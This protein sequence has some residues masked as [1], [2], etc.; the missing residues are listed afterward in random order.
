MPTITKSCTLMEKYITHI[1]NGKKTVEARVATGMFS[2][3]GVGDKVRFF[4]RKNPAISVTVKIV[5]VNKYNSFKEMIL[6]ESPENL[7]PGL[8]SVAEAEHEYLRIPGYAEKEHIG[9]LAFHIKTED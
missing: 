9:I 8:Y 4:S 7:I 1:K 5:K 3:W 2:K 6:A